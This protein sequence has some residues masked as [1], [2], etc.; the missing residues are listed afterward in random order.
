MGRMLDTLNQADAAPRERPHLAVAAV[1]PIRVIAD[2]DGGDGDEVET[3][4]LPVPPVPAMLVEPEEVEAEEDKSAP[5]IE[6]GGPRSQVD[7]SPEVLAFPATRSAPPS[8]K[9]VA[10]D[11]NLDVGGTSEIWCSWTLRPGMKAAQ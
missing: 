9:P 1:P 2:D 10:D 11:E 5:F 8:A 3:I 6:V 7:A 4:A